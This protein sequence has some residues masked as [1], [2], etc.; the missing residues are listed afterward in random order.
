VTRIEEELPGGEP[1]EPKP[2][3][4]R[5]GDNAAVRSNH[6]RETASP[7]LEMHGG[8]DDV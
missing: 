1:F 5:S 6:R 3:L 7:T 4:E 2:R 8:V